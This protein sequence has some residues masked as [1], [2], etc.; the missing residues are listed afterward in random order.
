V[1]QRICHL[2]RQ[3]QLMNIRIQNLFARLGVASTRSRVLP[4]LIAGLGLLPAGWATAQTFTTLG[5]F[6]YID[7]GL[8]FCSL[9]LS[10]NTLYGTATVGGSGSG[11]VFAI[12][13]DSA[14]IT[15]PHVFNGNDGAYPNGGLVLSGSTLYGTTVGG[16]TNNFGAVFAINIGGTG[17]RNLHSFD[18]SDGAYPYAG[19]ILS[20]NTLYGTA[21]QGGLGG[22][23]TV[24]AINT[25]G[26]GFTNLHNFG[27]GDGAHPYAG[28]IL[29]GN[30]LY[31]TTVNGGSSADGAGTVF[32]VNINGTGFTNLHSFSE[33]NYNSIE[34]YTNG[35]G[36]FPGAG[37]ILSGNTLYGTTDDGGTNG[38]GTVF[39]VNA[40]TLGFMNLH[41]F[42][43]YD[44]AY[45]NGSFVLSGN[46]L[47]GTAQYGGTSDNG[48]VFAININGTGFTNLYDFEALDSA[49]TN[50][51]G[52]NPED[53]LILSGNTLYGTAH[54]GG[55]T[56]D[57]TVFSLSLGSVSA[58]QLT[59]IPSST[60]VILTWPANAASY[61]LQ[62][63]TNLASPAVWSAVSPGPVLVNGQNTVTNVISGTQ[64]FF[65]MANP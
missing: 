17:F 25:G 7:G 64:Q 13:I 34:V 61:T 4:A 57:G 24:F 46:S 19:L 43:G 10:G 20:G 9:V 23:G 29:S 21:Q 3:E 59:I 2:N 22:S 48:T 39:A 50:S 49:G 44:G 51:D 47:Y 42:T 62:S 31:G 58:P 8:P 5:R 63:T 18:Y 12:N 14:D 54:A 45:P 36:A 26:S 11:T 38:Y 32:A 16:G 56:D 30:T 52:A 33:E 6:D 40:N 41:N 65:R 35:D 1:E 15:N 55:P 60:N 27:G 28:L 37:L 53:G